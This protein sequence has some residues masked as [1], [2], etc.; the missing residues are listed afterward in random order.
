MLGDLLDAM[1]C[2]RVQAGDIDSPPA[3]PMKA[4]VEIRS[5]LPLRALV[6]A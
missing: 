1:C 6:A 3:P 5:A 2:L 4:V